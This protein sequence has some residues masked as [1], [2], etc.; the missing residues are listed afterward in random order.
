MRNPNWILLAAATAALAEGC[1]SAAREPRVPV[2]PLGMREVQT[3]YFERTTAT[4]ALKAVIDM[5]Q[6]GEFTI[7]R[8][9]ADLGLVVGTRSRVQNP[10]GD[11]KALKWT[12]ILFTYGLAALL[13]WS[14][15][16]ATEIEADVNVTAVGEGV[17]VRMTLQRR[18]L[19]KN[20]RLERAE[21]LTDSALYRDLFELLDR[22]L[23]VA[24]AS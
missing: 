22:S 11:Q 10:S 18:I 9:D 8:T 24:Q 12:A 3:R 5:L 21:A 6:D 17:R 16:E 13:P 4:D 14:K 20:G 15:S 23:F 19:D 1:A 2:A 7:D